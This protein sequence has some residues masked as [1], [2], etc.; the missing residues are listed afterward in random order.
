LHTAGVLADYGAWLAECGR[1]DEALPLL[2][3]A[4]GFFA[5]VGARRW[6]EC[7]DAFQPDAAVPA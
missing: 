6:V 5:S 3:E 7:I 1:A 2:A 4:R